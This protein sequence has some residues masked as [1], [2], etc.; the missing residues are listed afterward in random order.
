MR[1][2]FV[3]KVSDGNRF[4]C[5]PVFVGKRRHATSYR[6]LI[7]SR[8]SEYIGPIALGDQSPLAV[9]TLIEDWWAVKKA[10]G[11]A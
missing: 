11:M 1:R 4:T 7:R 8:T 3:V 5:E 10:M 2:V 9:R 6:W